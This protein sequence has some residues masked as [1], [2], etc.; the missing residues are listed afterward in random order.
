MCQFPRPK[1]EM[2]EGLSI[3]Q[4]A[5]ALP[6]S[7]RRA[8]RRQPVV[9]EAGVSDQLLVAGV[10][11]QSLCGREGAGVSDPPKDAWSHKSRPR[12]SQS[13]LV[14]GSF[15]HSLSVQCRNFLVPRLLTRKAREERRCSTS[16]QLSP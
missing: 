1:G 12:R 6:W 9:D 10:L 11:P 5:V 4:W 14:D 15:D 8:S 2:V 7:P 3:L 16:W 13:K